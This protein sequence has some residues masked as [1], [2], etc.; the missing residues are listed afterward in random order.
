[1]E[2]T[3]DPGPGDGWDNVVVGAV[4]DVRPH[5]NADRLRLADVDTGGETS[6]VVCG[7]PNVAAGQKIAFARVGAMLTSGKTGEPMELTAAVIRGVESAGMVCSERELG[8]SDEHEGI[9]VLPDDSPIGTPLV[10]VLPSSGALEVEVTPNRGDCLSVLGIAHEAAAITGEQVTEPPSGYDEKGGA[11]ADSVGIEIA[12]PALCSRYTC[13]LVRGVQIGPSPDWLR[14]RLQD[15]GHRSIN[16]VVDVTNYVM[17]EYGQPLHA[18]DLDEVRDAKVIVRPASDGESFTSLDGQEHELRPPM[19]MIA[20]PERSIGLAGVMGG[21]NSEMTDATQNVLL[22]SA[23]FNAINTRRTSNALKL[24]TD[25]SLRFEKGLNPELAVRAV[26]RATRLILETAGGAAAQGVYDVFPGRSDPPRIPFS[27]ESLRRVLGVDFPTEQV[28]GVLASLGFSVELGA[29]GTMIVVPPYWRTDVGIEEDIVEEVARIVG[30]DA[31]EGEPLGGRVPEAIRQP[32]RELREE[33][34]DALVSFGLQETISHTLVSGEDA[35]LPDGAPLATANPMSQEQ[36]YLRT[37]LRPA[38][39]RGAASAMRQQGGVGMFE[40]GR[41]FIPRD[42]DLPDERETATAVLAGPR[43]SVLWEQDVESLGFFDA[44][45]IVEGALAHLGLS[46]TFER[47]TDPLLHPGRAAAV[48]VNGEQAG[49]VGELRPQAVAQYDI[50]AAQAAFIELDLQRLAPHVPEMRSS[51]T[52]FSRYPSAV[53][54]LALVLDV[55]VPARQ[56]QE[57]I[58]SGPLVIR[59]T[60]FDL[61]EGDP[62]PEGKKSLAFTVEF[63]SPS[64][65][66]ETAEV[67]DA[68]AA[69]VKRMER[70]TGASLRA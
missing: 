44:K 41:V 35:A 69:I 43:G 2:T 32:E 16:N 7:A 46:A 37:S 70:E 67:N 42:G 52:A 31:V 38:L 13:T 62:L 15:A 68:V 24:R 22:E 36:A 50:P 55:S 64:K 9:L 47:T 6:T 26:R 21:A 56:A 45:G 4:V 17:L 48:L 29:D 28:S 20:D 40:V 30:Y 63:Q 49:V 3:Y 57:I 19:L 39:L 14:Q 51:F 25:A 8:L 59:A 61:F 54:D 33:V 27:H 1:M 60:L 65:T 18:F 34:R 5:P 11:I 12:D 58:E 53:R 23:T 66:L 10:D